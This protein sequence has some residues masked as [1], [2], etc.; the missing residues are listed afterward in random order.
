MRRGEIY[1]KKNH[2]CTEDPNPDLCCMGYKK[3]QLSVLWH[4]TGFGCGQT[5]VFLLVLYGHSFYDRQAANDL[6][7]NV[8]NL[9]VSMQLLHVPR[10]L[11]YGAAFCLQLFNLLIQEETLAAEACQLLAQVLDTFTA[12]GC[13]LHR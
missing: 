3:K 11:L 13:S 2:Q 7:S 4:T 5:V 6:M 8:L 10:K 9:V 12:C 1:G